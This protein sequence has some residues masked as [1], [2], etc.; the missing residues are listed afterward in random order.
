VPSSFTGGQIYYG[1][2]DC[3]FYPA[4]G[5]AWVATSTLDSLRGSVSAKGG[6]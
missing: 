1:G 6:T 3:N 4:D 5:T 2:Y